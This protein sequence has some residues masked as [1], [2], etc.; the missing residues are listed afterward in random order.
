MTNQRGSTSVLVIIM[1]IVLLVFGLAILTTSLSNVRLADK[2]INWLKDYYLLEA[3]A[4][5][6][7][8][9]LDQL[10]DKRYLPDVTVATQV[11]TFKDNLSKSYA[12]APLEWLEDN[13]TAWLAKITVPMTTSDW[14]RGLNLVIA[15]PKQ[16]TGPGIAY[17]LKEHSQWQEDFEFDFLSGFDDPLE[18]EVDFFEPEDQ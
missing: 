14:A 3:D 2:K 5:Q 18:D 17:T 4:A 7:L 15:I 8:A 16:Q 12:Y 11:E 10:L 6:A 13:D 1:M 9:E